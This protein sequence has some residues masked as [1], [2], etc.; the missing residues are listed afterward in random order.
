MEAADIALAIEGLSGQEEG[1]DQEALSR[2]NTFRR[3][4]IYKP[5]KQTESDNFITPKAR[6]LPPEPQPGTLHVHQSGSS[7]SKLDA[8]LS[9]FAESELL[10]SLFLA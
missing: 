7:G 9:H 6:A 1:G 8:I 2:D 3:K 5:S 10:S 4:A